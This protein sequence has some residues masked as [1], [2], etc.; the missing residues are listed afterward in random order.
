MQKVDLRKVWVAVVD[1]PATL[2]RIEARALFPPPEVCQYGVKSAGH[3]LEDVP[4]DVRKE[5]ERV[6]RVARGNIEVPEAWDTVDDEVGVSRVSDPADLGALQTVVRQLGHVLCQKQLRLAFAGDGDRVRR[7]HVLEPWERHRLARA[8]GGVRVW[9]TVGDPGTREG[10]LEQLRGRIRREEVTHPDIEE[11]RTILIF[12]VLFVGQ[13]DECHKEPRCRLLTFEVDESAGVGSEGNEHIAGGERPPALS[14]NRRTSDFFAGGGRPPH[15]ADGL[16][17]GPKRKLDAQ[18][19]GLRVDGDQSLGR[20]CEPAVGIELR[21]FAGGEAVVAEEGESGC[22]L[23]AADDALD[24]EA[25]AELLEVVNA[26]LVEL[27]P[28]DVILRGDHDPAA[29]AVDALEFRISLPKFD[30]LHAEFRV[31]LGVVLSTHNL[32]VVAGCGPGGRRLVRVYRSDLV[33]G[34]GKLDC[35]GESEDTASN[36]QYRLVCFTHMA[37]CLLQIM[38]EKVMLRQNSLLPLPY[39][40]KLLLPKLLDIPA[41][42]SFI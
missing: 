3:P 5:L 20:M 14:E 41:D 36:N 2:G 7:I 15:H 19:A 25:L 6:S 22:E 17:V 27:L 31:Y 9:Q 29:V 40:P 24:V 10:H 18:A 34:L 38:S 1:T 11:D 33:P 42:S 4:S 39:H 12:L 37:V 8:G 16:P 28:C 21:L 26:G 13:L 30:G 23:V 35:G 32:V